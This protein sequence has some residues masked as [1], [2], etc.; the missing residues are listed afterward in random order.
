M[1]SL[2]T[3][4]TKSAHSQTRNTDSDLAS[5]EPRLFHSKKWQFDRFS[6]KSNLDVL[7]MRKNSIKS[8]LHF[9]WTLQW[10]LE[11]KIFNLRGSFL[12]F[13]SL[14]SSFERQCAWKSF[15]WWLWKSWLRAC[16]HWW[17]R[18]SSFAFSLLSELT[19]KWRWVCVWCAKS[20]AICHA[21]KTSFHL[22]KNGKG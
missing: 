21:T 1:Y 22:L 8:K 19:S 18:T 6:S 16:M 15:W 5:L 2:D 3:D 4:L 10:L 11:A 17:P 14:F 13:V 20:T 9:L 7:N 12:L